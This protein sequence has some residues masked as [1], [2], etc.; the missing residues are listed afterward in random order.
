MNA[1][2]LRTIGV[3]TVSC[4]FLTLTAYAESASRAAAV[5]DSMPHAK[6]ISQAAIS[7]D[8]TQIAYIVG[9]ELSLIP[10]TGG[11]VALPTVALSLRVVL[12]AQNDPK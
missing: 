2:S 9:G 5:L 8:G 6:S 3:I 12:R 1:L 11:T 10:A 7:P 4:V